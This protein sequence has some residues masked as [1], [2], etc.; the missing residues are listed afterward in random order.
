MK[1][2]NCY[3]LIVVF[4][5]LSGI[6]F[7]QIPDSV[8]VSKL[9]PF[10]VDSISIKGNEQTE[11]FIIRRELTFNIGDTLSAEI[12]NY[13]RER[14]YSLGLFAHV[15]VFPVEKNSINI[16][17]IVVEE[18]W[19]IY[20][21]PFVT[22]KEKD[23]NK[24]SFG[25][26][27]KINN[28]R[29]R[30]EEI[31][32]VTAF[33]YDPAFSLNYYNPNLIGK[34]DFFLRTVFIYSDVNNKSPSA[35]NLYGEKFSQ[36]YFRIHLLI[37]KRIDLFHKLC[38]AT[39]FNYYETPKY[40]SG[41]NVSS[42]R[43]DRFPELQFGYEFDSRDLIQFPRNG[44]FASASLSFKGLGVN[45]INYNVARIDFREYRRIVG[46]LF[47]KWRFSARFTN[48]SEIPFYD[49]S[50]LGIDEKVRGYFTRKNEGN[51]FYFASAEFFYPIIEELNLNFDFIPIIPEQL[52]KFR[53]ALYTQAFGDAGTTQYKHQPLSFNRFISGYGLGITLLVL[54]YNIL[55][56]EYALD[57]FGKKE[58]IFDLGISF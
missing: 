15:Y 38:L 27:L 42:E 14:I 16:L 3:K 4:L 2:N 47:S 46:N 54:P 49:Y 20:P 31:T 55:R 8:S 18:R 25:I 48:G 44:I 11:E 34:E 22:I 1:N 17:E 41:I 10:K 50:I 40:F 13:N 39:A 53:I 5:L 29:G 45:S 6:S 35:E 21:I 51:H 12:V 33:G 52:L 9:Y 43:I 26:Y 32:A 36:K 23:F 58:W 57:N 7:S 37:G 30:N 28:F 24:L 19:Y 56:I